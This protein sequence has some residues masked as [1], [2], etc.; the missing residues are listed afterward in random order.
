MEQCK[1]CYRDGARGCEAFKHR[2]KECFARITDRE[3]Y[4]KEQNELIAYNEGRCDQAINQARR[5]I[6]RVTK[7][8]NT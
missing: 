5:N 8:A 4:I 2:P 1:D 6:K 3:Q 7:G